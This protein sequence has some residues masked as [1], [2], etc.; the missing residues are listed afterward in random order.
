[1]GNAPCMCGVS[2]HREILLIGLGW[3][4]WLLIMALPYLVVVWYRKDDHHPDQSQ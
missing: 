4:L 3:R 1:M 2:L